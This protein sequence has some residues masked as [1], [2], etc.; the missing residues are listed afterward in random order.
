MKKHGVESV[1][2]LHLM[3]KGFWVLFFFQPAQIEA[4][5]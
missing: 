1:L 5:E 2:L 4:F 3:G